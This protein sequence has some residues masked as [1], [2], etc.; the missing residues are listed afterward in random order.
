MQTL[1]ARNREWAARMVREDPEFFTR[2]ANQQ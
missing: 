1:L 2:L